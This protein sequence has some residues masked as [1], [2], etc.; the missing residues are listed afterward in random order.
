[1]GKSYPKG[2]AIMFPFP[3]ALYSQ[4]GDHLV[5]FIQRNILWRNLCSLPRLFKGFSATFPCAF[6]CAKKASISRTYLSPFHHPTCHM[7]CFYESVASHLAQKSS[8]GWEKPP[9][10][11]AR[12]A[13][14]LCPLPPWFVTAPRAAGPCLGTRMSARPH[15]DRAS[16]AV[17][18]ERGPEGSPGRAVRPGRL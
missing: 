3:S 7:Q 8:G 18:A 9:H 5:L 6:T 2:K 10:T 4:P 16:P 14:L 1:M 13:P 15:P 11:A 12:Q 17:P